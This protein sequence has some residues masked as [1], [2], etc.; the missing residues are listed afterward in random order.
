MYPGALPLTQAP[1]HPD[2][3][4]EMKHILDRNAPWNR[5]RSRRSTGCLFSWAAAATPETPEG[6]LHPCHFLFI[7]PRHYLPTRL[8]MQLMIMTQ[9]APSPMLLCQPLRLEPKRAHTRAPGSLMLLKARE[10]HMRLE[11]LMHHL[12][13]LI[14]HV[15]ALWW[16]MRDACGLTAVLL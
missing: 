13:R 7:S 12:S 4:L 3:L 9:W 6:T 2:P 8:R 11:S 5:C 1:H 14:Q 10:K 15:R 16:W